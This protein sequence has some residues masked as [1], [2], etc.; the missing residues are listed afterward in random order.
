MT[1]ILNL[2]QLHRWPVGV[3]TLVKRKR[4]ETSYRG[5]QENIPYKLQTDGIISFMHK[6]INNTDSWFTYTLSNRHT[7]RYQYKPRS[8]EVHIYIDIIHSLLASPT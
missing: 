5:A 2:I 6:R 4:A 7:G 1:K 3:G 8:V